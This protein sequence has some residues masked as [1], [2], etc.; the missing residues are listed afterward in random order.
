MRSLLL[1]V[2][3]TSSL[4]SSVIL[5]LVAVIAIG[6]AGFLFV[7]ERVCLVVSASSSVASSVLF[8]KDSRRRGL[9]VGDLTGSSLS[10]VSVSLWVLL[11]A[12][13]GG[14]LYLVDDLV[15]RFGGPTLSSSVM[16]LTCVGL[17]V[18]MRFRDLGAFDRVPIYYMS[19]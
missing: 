3:T 18:S 9:F 6:C 15:F 14:L 13:F 8:K 12:I 17:R 1:G 11:F 7:F 16:L 5:E 10:S 2:T 4:E 19:A